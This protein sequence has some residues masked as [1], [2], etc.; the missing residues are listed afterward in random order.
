MRLPSRSCSTQYLSP[1]SAYRV[2]LL[3]ERC[4]EVD[5]GSRGV[6]LEPR[7]DA[8]AQA[9]EQLRR[10]IAVPA[11]QASRTHVVQRVRRN[12]CVAELAR[13]RQRSCARRLSVV[14]PP[15]DHAELRPVAVRH[16]ELTS[17]CQEL[18]DTDRLSGCPL[19]QGRQPTQPV[20][21]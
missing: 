3:R 9:L 14:R 4:R 17:R 2:V 20:Q 18:E 6:V 16:R 8:K 21:A 10:A 11:H 19:C 12:L 1:S 13:E 7:V 5:P 15:R